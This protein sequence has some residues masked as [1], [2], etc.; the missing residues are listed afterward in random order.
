MTTSLLM[1]TERRKR[2]KN[3]IQS[4]AIALPLI[5]RNRIALALNCTSDMSRKTNS[6]FLSN[7]QLIMS[8]VVEEMR[9]RLS[10]RRD[11]RC[12]KWPAYCTFWEHTVDNWPEDVFKTRFRM[13]RSM[14]QHIL[15]FVREDLSKPA[16]KFGHDSSYLIKPEKRLAITLYYL[17]SGAAIPAVADLFSVGVSSVRSVLYETINFLHQRLP[18]PRLPQT[19]TERRKIAQEFYNLRSHYPFP[20]VLGT[21][22]GCHIPITTPLDDPADYFNY[23]KFHSIIL[24]AVAG[25]SSEFLFYHIGCAGKNNDGFVFD[26]CGLKSWCQNLPLSYHLLGDSA[27]PISTG[28]MKGYAGNELTLQ[29]CEKVFNFALSSTRMTIECAFGI[30]KARFRCLLVK[31]PFRDINLLCVLVSTC[32]LL[33]NLLLED[34]DSAAAVEMERD[35]DAG[36][37]ERLIESYRLTSPNPE[38]D[39]EEETLA[40]I[41]RN[42]L[43]NEITC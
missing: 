17:S 42:A 5:Q 35:F 36:V 28:L 32:I 39:V 19:L 27:F 1:D 41:K 25:S 26:Y 29:D 22:D 20:G 18:K 4:M 14:F 31:L 21:V 34:R 16:L 23:K 9:N 6:L 30:L 10:N 33:H 43:K 38:E 13:T 11:R 2:I 12:W 7:R 3:T 15:G 37:V 40:T 8:Q 24:M